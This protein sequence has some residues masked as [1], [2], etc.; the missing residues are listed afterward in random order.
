M[1]ISIIPFSKLNTSNLGFYNIRAR[2]ITPP[3]NHNGWKKLE[4]HITYD[5][6]G[7][8]TY[9]NLFLLSLNGHA[10]IE[11][12]NITYELPP[13]TLY[14][15]PPQIESIIY[16]E[17]PNYSY[18]RIEFLAKDLLT[19]ELVS[20]SDRIEILTNNIPKN[21]QHNMLEFCNA[22]TFSNTTSNLTLS[23]YACEFLY[24]IYTQLNLTSKST[25]SKVYNA[26]SHLNQFY[27][28]NP[29]DAELAE[30]CNLSEQ[31]FRK[32]FKEAT[33]MTPVEYKNHR[34]IQ[35]DC[36]ML[37]NSPFTIDHISEKL[38]FSQVNYFCRTFKAVMGVSATYYRNYM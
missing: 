37:K 1:N 11:Y 32:C 4:Y 26:I 9:R 22:Y 28:L 8:K 16:S 12:K 29:T 31:Y 36:E 18:Y 30:M 14:Y 27:H 2:H 25:Y 35:R 20:F 6:F 15:I 23:S 3:L 7:N 24:D 10:A 17:T 13:G 38:G 34:K 33:K 19:N 5:G 21:L